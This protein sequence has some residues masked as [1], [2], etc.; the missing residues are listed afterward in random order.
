MHNHARPI[1]L[2]VCKYRI[3]YVVDFMLHC[4]FKIFIWRDKVTMLDTLSPIYGYMDLSVC[5]INSYTEFSISFLVDPFL[6]DKR[7]LLH[8]Q[9]ALSDYGCLTPF[10]YMNYENLIYIIN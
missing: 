10:A 8:N 7:T 9:S 2:F 4:I 1:N 3:V 6:F 5:F